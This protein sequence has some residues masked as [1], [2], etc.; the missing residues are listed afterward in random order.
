MLI[1]K[2][3]IFCSSISLAIRSDARH[4][5]PRHESITLHNHELIR[6]KT[7]IMRSQLK[8]ERG[9]FFLPHWY[10]NHGP[11]EAKASGLPMRYVAQHVKFK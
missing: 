7:A 5:G 3:S 2:L 1:V 8:K 10:L 6:R 9:I 11:L 4:E